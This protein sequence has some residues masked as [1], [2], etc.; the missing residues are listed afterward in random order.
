MTQGVYILVLRLLCETSVEIGRLGVQRFSAG[1][2]AYAGSAMNGLEGRI[3]RHLRSRKAKRWHIDYLREVATVEGVWVLPGAKQRE[4]SL[5][6]ELLRM[7][8]A[9]PGPRGFGSSDCPCDTH[10]VHFA[11]RPAMEAIE[12]GW[13][14]RQMPVEP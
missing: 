3:R 1:H 6:A 10:L 4:C 12:R 8:G 2:Y 9:Q 11:D 7:P 13:G 14:L 5:A